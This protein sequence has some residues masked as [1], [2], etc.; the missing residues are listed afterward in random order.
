MEKYSNKQIKIQAAHVLGSFTNV[1]STTGESFN[2]AS[3]VIDSVSKSVATIHRENLLAIGNTVQLSGENCVAGQTAT[4]S[5]GNIRYDSAGNPVV[6]T[7]DH[8]RVNNFT[9]VDSRFRIADLDLLIAKEMAKEMLAARKSSAAS[10]IIAEPAI[11]TPKAPVIEPET[12]KSPE[13]DAAV[14]AAL[15]KQAQD[16]AVADAVAAALAA[17]QVPTT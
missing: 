2:V 11:E 10:M 15:A 7:K 1:V 14:Q 13:V 8:Y 3:I 12:V 16:K 5:K 4:D 17:S 9:V 6:Y